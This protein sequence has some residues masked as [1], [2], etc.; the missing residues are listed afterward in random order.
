MLAHLECGQLQ[1]LGAICL[2]AV[3]ACTAARE[4]DTSQAGDTAARSADSPP[5]AQSPMITTDRQSYQ[6]RR[7]ADAIEV[8]IVTTFTNHTNDTV[9]LHPCGQ[10]QPAFTLE[11][12][13]EGAWRPA[14]NQVC[15]AMLNLD[16]PAVAPHAART[17]T[18]R[19]RAM[20]A[21]NAAPRFEAE[22]VAGTYRVVYAQAYRTWRPN[23][24]P[25]ELL[26]M[27]H[28]VSNSFVLQE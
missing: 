13:V 20:T 12:W 2:F 26:P 19:V 4:D 28:R 10:S 7:T 17:D 23:E 8:D 24:G 22:P 16:P 6:V 9:R 15:P 14:Y 27:E 11:K 3:A 25:G 18:A 21:A 1:R 5:P